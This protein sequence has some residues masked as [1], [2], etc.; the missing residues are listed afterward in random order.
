MENSE[1][2]TPPEVDNIVDFNLDHI[3]IC[4]CVYRT[5]LNMRTCPRCNQ[6]YC[7]HYASKI[8]FTFCVYC[9]S[10]LVIEDSIIRKVVE[11]KS[12]TGK[13]TFTRVMRARHIVFKGQDWMFAQAR[14]TTLTD[15]ELN[16]SILYHNTIFK[17]MINEMEARKIARNKQAMSKMMKGAS[18]K[19]PNVAK[20]GTYTDGTIIG[21]DSTTITET[22]V[23]R[24]RITAT[25][26]NS[27]SVALNAII[28]VL[29][30]QG[31]NNEQIQNKLKA[32][33]G[34]K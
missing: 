34:G 25:Q 26:T 16:D 6:E 33:A 18:L 31:L 22:T 15:Q 9:F 24:T 27:V 12:L 20:K 4:D 30:A 7:P 19:I 11:S 3:R 29:K 14:V 23:K 1:Q 2:E 21:T 5:P 13:K 10:D 8:D 17:E 32:M 28:A